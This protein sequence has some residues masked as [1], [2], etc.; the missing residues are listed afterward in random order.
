MAMEDDDDDEADAT[1][2]LGLDDETADEVEHFAEQLGIEPDDYGLF[3]LM[4][5][6]EVLKLLSDES[7]A[8]GPEAFEC[9]KRAA[10][11]LFEGP[12]EALPN[13]RAEAATVRRACEML[14]AIARDTLAD[15]D[16]ASS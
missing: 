13:V 15:D 8:G 11:E 7:G 12:T 14:V 9:V 10:H 2:Q 5:T 16:D 4:F 1:I 3:A 6:N